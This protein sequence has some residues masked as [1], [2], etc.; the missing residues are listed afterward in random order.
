MFIPG[1]V[2][3]RKWGIFILA[4]GT[5]V[6]IE[7]ILIVDEV[8]RKRTITFGVNPMIAKGT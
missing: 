2:T 7:N 5:K 6:I 3:R 4:F 1:I 8:I